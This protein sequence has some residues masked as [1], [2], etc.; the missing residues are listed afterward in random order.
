VTDLATDPFAGARAVADTVLLEGYVLYPY[1]ASAAKNRVRWQFGVLV[2][3]ASATAHGEHSATRTECLIDPRDSDELCVELRFLRVVRRVVEAASENGFH[4]VDR[5]PVGETVHLPWDEGTVETARLDVPLA[6][7]LEAP[8]T[9]ISELPGGRTVDVLEPPVGRLVRTSMPVR[10]RLTISA[11]RLPGPY[12]VLRLRI[13]V[14]NVT[15]PS[16]PTDD[17]NDAL[18]HSLIAAH[19]LLGL[20]RGQFLSLAGPP[21]WALPAAAGCVNEH[22]WPVLV[23][24]RADADRA[25]V[26]LS[27]PIILDDHPQLAPESEHA[28]YDST[29]VDEILTLRTMTLTDEEKREARG[30]DPRAAAVIDAVD[31]KPPELLDRLHGA[32]RSMHAVPTIRTPGDELAAAAPESAPPLLPWWDPG[33]DDTVDPEHDSVDI[34]GVAVRKG[35]R[36]L[37]RP[38]IRGADA[39]DLFLDG[40]TATVQAVLHDVDGDVQV[41]VSVDDDPLAE[42]QAATGRYRYFRPDELAPLSGGA[43]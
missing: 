42:I 20:R 30:T 31:G 28:L 40:L 27:S 7:L 43:E 38:G 26:V 37:L 3:H 22:T 17:R 2:P 5:L 34:A 6:E 41:A 13:D 15:E 9:R 23:G 4:P 1:R 21:E 29:E 8:V 10:F 39:Q 19:L 36:V 35:C 32:I 33:G 11:A 18:R 16:A 25:G 12:G 14:E 24:G